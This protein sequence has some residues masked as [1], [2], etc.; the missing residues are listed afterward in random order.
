MS[1]LNT[2]YAKTLTQY[3]VAGLV[4]V[5]VGAVYGLVTNRFGPQ[6]VA[7]LLAFIVVGVLAARLLSAPLRRIRVEAQTDE[8]D[9]AIRPADPST[10]AVDFAPAWLDR[11]RKAQG[12]MSV[13]AAYQEN[14]SRAV[15]SLL[16]GN[17]AVE[18]A[19]AKLATAADTS[20]VYDE[21]LREALRRYATLP[22]AFASALSRSLRDIVAPFERTMQMAVLIESQPLRQFLERSNAFEVAFTKLATSLPGSTSA[23]ERAVREAL[24]PYGIASS[25][26]G[27]GLSTNYRELAT[28]YDRRMQL[29]S[30]FG[31]EPRRREPQRSVEQSL[32]SLSDAVGGTASEAARQQEIS[33][34]VSRRKRLRIGIPHH[35]RGLASVG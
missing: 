3:V 32:D 34:G 4:L 7:V 27:T 29:G 33:A 8:L 12:A 11:A 30:R 9:A 14:A 28:V 16:A 15:E 2:P 26:F 31:G 1:L 20:S 18:Q 21:A 6:P 23:Y 24:R 17:K 22:Q 25:A 13:V 5:P 19:V 35:R 10:F